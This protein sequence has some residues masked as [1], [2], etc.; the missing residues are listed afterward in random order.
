MNLA[1]LK[2]SG[3]DYVVL[4][5]KRYEQLAAVEEDQRDA[6]QARK[7]LARYRAGRLKTISHDKVKKKLGI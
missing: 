2:L 7:L 4:P 5:R 1:T 3:K 6:A